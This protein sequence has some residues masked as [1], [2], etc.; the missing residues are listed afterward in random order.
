MNF[1]ENCFNFNLQYSFLNKFRYKSLS[2]MPK[3]KKLVLTTKV[4]KYKTRELAL[5]FLILELL[6]GRDLTFKIFKTKKP[7]LILKLRKGIPIGVM[8]ILK[9]QIKIFCVLTK[10]FHFKLLKN[11]KKNINNVINL[12]KI[13]K[14]YINFSIK[15][16]I[17][18]LKKIALFYNLFIYNKLNFT[19]NI[20]FYNKLQKEIAFIYKYFIKD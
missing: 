5:N 14:N 16:D 9:K 11:H 19:I 4:S 13:K 2:K 10:F 17:L 20:I 12:K 6:I 3:I 7:N 15:N 18:N 8:V 1:I